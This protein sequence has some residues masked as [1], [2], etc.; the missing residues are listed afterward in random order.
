MSGQAGQKL[1]YRAYPGLHHVLL[2][3][4]NSPHIP[5]LLTWT[6]NRFEGAAAPNNCST[7][8]TG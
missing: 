5:Y 8:P 1:E 4:P 7:L 2:V 6:E 3:Q